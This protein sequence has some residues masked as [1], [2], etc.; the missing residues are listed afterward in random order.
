[1][2]TA[3]I[4]G[5]GNIG[6]GFIGQLFSES[7][8]EVVFVDVDRPLLDALNA[9]HAYTIE[10]VDNDGARALRVGPVRAIAAGD[11]AAVAAAVAG[12]AIMA[13]AVGARVLPAIAPNV[14]AGIR[15]RQQS[16]AA[17]PLNCIVCENLKGA[18]SVI[19]DL[20]AGHLSPNE[21]AY[22]DE[23]VG[24]V[25]TVIGR[26]V[27]PL[28][29]E[30]RARDPARIRV[31]PYKELPVDRAGL[32]G[33]IPAIEAM[34]PCDRFEVYTA[35]KLYIHNCGHAVLAYLGYLAGYSYGYEALADPA[36]S[37]ALDQAWEESIAGQ[38][39]HYGVEASWLRVH[40][41]DLRRRFANRA[42]GDTVYRLGRDPIRKLGP[43]D[44]LVA[45]ARLAQEA[46]VTPRALARA[47]A[48]ALRFDPPRDPVAVQLQVRLADEGLD[49]VL[50]DVCAIDPGEELAHLI[51]DHYA[52]LS[53]SFRT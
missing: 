27:P 26:M 4:F 40:A 48:A 14:A 36:I 53:S 35:R 6:R 8:Y 21:R 44:R 11:S 43:S 34:Q 17:A 29:S 32:I 47:I 51:R 45:P 39:A 25:N 22:L 3:V 37:A 10:L 9:N 38:V 19:R 50:A 52:A 1:M 24:F 15:L 33:P 30:M 49:A 12:A 13:T 7:G 46:G 20:V 31:E 18:A 16:G 28:T 2:D 5:A 23:H 41:A 42:L